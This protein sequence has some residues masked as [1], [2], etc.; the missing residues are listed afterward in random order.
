MSEPN[1]VVSTIG[2]HHQTDPQTVRS[3]QHSQ[4]CGYEAVSC[5]RM[6]LLQRDTFHCSALRSLVGRGSSYRWR[7]RTM[8]AL[9]IF[10][11]I[12]W[13]K[14]CGV[15]GHGNQIQCIQDVMS[16]GGS[17]N[18]A[19]EQVVNQQAMKVLMRWRIQML[20]RADSE[21]DLFHCKELHLNGGRIWKDCSHNTCNPSQLQYSMT[22]I[23]F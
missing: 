6:N 11:Q 21:M 15:S 1:L 13:L 12:I 8:T 22:L 4:S 3:S 7:Q 17:T 5:Y 20:N 23:S 19:M 10:L 18:G 16:L 9:W 14:G 2:N